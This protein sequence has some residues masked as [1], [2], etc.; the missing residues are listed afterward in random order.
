MSSQYQLE[1]KTIPS[2]QRT[3]ASFS[4]CLVQTFPAYIHWLGSQLNHHQTQRLHSHGTAN[5]LLFGDHL[6]TYLW[7]I[8]LGLLKIGKLA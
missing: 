6:P 4:N 7:A 5:T 8:L 3:L 1:V 2:K